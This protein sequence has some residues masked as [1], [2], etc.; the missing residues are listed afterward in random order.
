[1]DDKALKKTLKTLVKKVG[2]VEARRLLVIAGVSPSTA[3][4][5]VGNRYPSEVGRLL[6]ATIT[7]V[8]TEAGAQAAS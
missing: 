4:K 2:I 5:L 8:A 7:R 3:D 6:G 1:M